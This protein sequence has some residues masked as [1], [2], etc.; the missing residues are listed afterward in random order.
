M[1]LE[2]PRVYSYTSGMF[3][4]IG[5]FSAK[6]SLLNASHALGFLQPVRLILEYAV[7]KH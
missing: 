5:T 1:L 3:E 4:H 6:K 7:Y 2:L